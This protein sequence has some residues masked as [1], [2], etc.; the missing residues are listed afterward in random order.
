MTSHAG[1]HTGGLPPGDEDRLIACADL[2][3]RAGARSFEIG[4]LHDN[5]PC[6][7]AGWYA[8]AYYR[9]GRL[10]ADDCRSPGEAADQLARQLLTGARCRCGR[11]VAL[12]H[13]GA[14]AWKRAVMTDGSTWTAEQAA[15]VT[16]RSGLCHW[17][18]HGRR[19][20]RECDGTG[21]EEAPA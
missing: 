8:T 14:F 16:A 5:V 4:Y 12:M 18:R 17:E 10:T 21:A 15:D 6:D 19:W 3:G 2:C 9:G 7:R 1:R 13:E 11:L 20:D